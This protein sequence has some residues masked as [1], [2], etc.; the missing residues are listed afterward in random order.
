MS[1]TDLIGMFTASSGGQTIQTP[2]VSGTGDQGAIRLRAGESM[3]ITGLSKQISK[4]DRNGLAEE[5]P[6]ALGG[7][8]KRGVKREHYLVVVRA[9]PI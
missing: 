6:I 4:S 2:E 7:S 9:T 8:V 5:I 1:M 3:V